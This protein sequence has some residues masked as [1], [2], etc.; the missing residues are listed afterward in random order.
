MSLELLLAIVSPNDSLLEN[1][2][3]LKKVEP[4][5]EGSKDGQNEGGEE[6]C[7]NKY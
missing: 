3:K 4:R 6:G 2:A 5:D 1:E 7:E